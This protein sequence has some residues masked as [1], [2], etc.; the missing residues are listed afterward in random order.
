PLLL[1]LDEERAAVQLKRHVRAL[2]D[3]VER[4]RLRDVDDEAARADRGD[5]PTDP[6]A[7][8]RDVDPYRRQRREVGAGG[9]DAEAHEI[10]GLDA[11]ERDRLVLP[12]RGDRRVGG[13]GDRLGLA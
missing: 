3:A 11:R 8:A 6:V 12:A 4:A 2:Q 5:R 7:V 10:A 9:G 13:D 1:A